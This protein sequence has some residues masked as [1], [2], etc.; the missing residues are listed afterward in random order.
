MG[1][2]A[3]RVI[4]PT[5]ADRSPL[6]LAAPMGYTASGWRGIPFERTIEFTFLV[7]ELAL[8]ALIDRKGRTNE[9]S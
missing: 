7:R 5:S 4:E 2:R 3:G 1:K 6:S 9:W 8:A